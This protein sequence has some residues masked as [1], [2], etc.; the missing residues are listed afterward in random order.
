M[1]AQHNYFGGNYKPVAQPTATPPAVVYSSTKELRSKTKQ[2]TGIKSSIAPVGVL[3]AKVIVGASSVSRPLL[4]SKSIFQHLFSTPLGMS[5]SSK[6]KLGC[7][8]FE[9][10]DKSTIESGNAGL[11]VGGF[12]R[13]NTRSNKYP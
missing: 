5:P 11:G 13:G 1:R 10:A 8:Q 12:R 2:N 7:T 6:F 3:R 9:D 4:G